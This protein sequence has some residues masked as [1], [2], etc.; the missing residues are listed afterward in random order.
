MAVCC[1]SQSK[2][3][4]ADTGKGR[5]FCACMLYPFDVEVIAKGMSDPLSVIFLDGV[6]Y[7]ADSGNNRV[8]YVVL[9]NSIF[10]EPNKMKVDDLREA[11]E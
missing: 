7:V 9:S 6:A 11:I 1:V 3:L 8:G 2:L 4:I 5:L 10:L